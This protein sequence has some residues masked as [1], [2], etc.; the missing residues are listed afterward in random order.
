MLAD[1]YLHVLKQLV[2]SVV[3]FDPYL[4]DTLHSGEVRVKLAQLIFKFR[5]LM[6][7]ITNLLCVCP[8]ICFN[9]QSFVTNLSHYC[10][11]VS[12]S[13]WES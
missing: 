1:F 10:G 4:L 9:K 2:L 12:S 13:Y 11:I 3:E 8:Y 7:P 5:G 6:V